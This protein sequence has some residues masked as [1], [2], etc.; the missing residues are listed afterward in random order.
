MRPTYADPPRLTL[1][2]LAETP[3]WLPTLPDDPMQADLEAAYLARGSSILSC[4]AARQLATDTL[5]AERSLIDQ[6][7]AQRPK[8]R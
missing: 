4:D 8:R 1:P 6:W 2:A 7:L 3:C 5:K